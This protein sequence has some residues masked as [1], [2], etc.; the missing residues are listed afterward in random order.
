MFPT[1]KKWFIPCE[2]NDYRPY[3]LRLV[4]VIAVFLVIGVLFTGSET[5]SRIL[6]NQDSYLAAIISSVLVD[7]TNTDRAIEG[8]HGLSVNQTLI[9]AAQLK[10]N[11]MAAKGYFAHNSP[12]GKN[13]WYFFKE[14]GYSFAYAGENLAVFFGDSE[15]VEQAWMNS[16]T[17]RANILSSNFTEIGIATAEGMYQ[18]RSTVFV[19]QMFGTPLKAAPIATLET[20]TIS[21][22]NNGEAGQVSGESVIVVTEE[23]VKQ[24]EPRVIHEDESFIAIKNENQMIAPSET[25]VEDQ[26]TFMER[27]LASPQSVFGDIAAL[28]MIIVTFAFISLIAFEFHIQRPKNI[29][30]G[31]FL[32]VVLAGTIYFVGTDVVV[33]SASI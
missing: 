12:D 10:A 28:M 7:L 1:F 21:N 15:D 23:N 30:L 22:E 26:S 14:A 32:L 3:A 24:I 2:S 11:D 9:E 27:L 18:G 16:P 33:A 25:S 20:D 8:L 29:A 4:P 13:P 5:V 17:H 6:K 19:V 31:I